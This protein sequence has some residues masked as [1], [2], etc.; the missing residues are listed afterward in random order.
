[1]QCDKHV[2]KMVLE[3]TQLLCSVFPEGEAPYKRT[4]YNHPCSK[5]ARECFDN[6]HWLMLH[7]IGLI[8]EYEYRYNRLHKCKQTYEWLLEHYESLTL[9]REIGTIPV[10]DLRVTS[11]AQAMPE[12]YKIVGDAVT[13][14]R[15]YYLQDKVRFA[16]WN[17]GRNPPSWFT[18]IGDRNGVS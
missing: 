9:P 8:E 16:K 17:R 13:A 5:W 11:F 14:Y 6:Y 15:N 3:T 4:H 1:M 2:V 12:Q 18:F 7:G 10:G